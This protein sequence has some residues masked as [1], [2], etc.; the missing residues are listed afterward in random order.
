[1]KQL[2]REDIHILSRHSN[3]SKENL[4]KLLRENIYSPKSAWYTFIKYLL[5]TLG[6]GFVVSGIVFFFAYN[7]ESLDKFVKL[8]ITQALV[9]LF[10]ILALYSKLSPT[11]RKILIT[12][13]A[14]LVGVLFAVYGQVY[15][16]GAD[17][18]DF[19]LIWALCVSI[20]VFVA[21]FAP[22]WLLYL[23]L[24]NVT[25]I[26]YVDQ[27]AIYE[28]K[29]YA[30]LILFVA[31]AL[32]LITATVLNKHS[33]VF[34]APNWLLLT[35]GTG[36]VILGSFAGI[37][38]VIVFSNASLA[39]WGCIAVL[40]TLGLWYGI[41]TINGFYLLAIPFSIMLILVA[42]LLEI[43]YS[44]IFLFVIGLFVIISTSLI[45]RNLLN[46]QKK[47]L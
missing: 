44:D 24:L 28:L 26:M 29:E 9:I 23:L 37:K 3:L 7:W 11:L 16:T 47:K 18:Y 45:I 41:K 14:A 27:V 12:A 43:F 8:G 21:N 25:F 30:F 32:V 31:N 1:M 10:A 35:I 36:V 20:W 2:Q 42:V 13:A 39:T 46:M 38:E 4:D 15:Q 33:K 19:F 5:V 6:V 17:A 22:L 34:T 40:Y